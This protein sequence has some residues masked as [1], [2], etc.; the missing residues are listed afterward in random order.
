MTSN[1]VPASDRPEPSPLT[2]YLA[3]R[4]RTPN[5]AAH[6]YYRCRKVIRCGSGLIT[7]ILLHSHHTRRR[8]RSTE[9]QAAIHSILHKGHSDEPWSSRHTSR[10]RQGRRTA[11]QGPVHPD[12]DALRPESDVTLIVP[13]GD[14]FVITDTV[15]VPIPV[16]PTTSVTATNG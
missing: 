4:C 14:A 9:E 10:P 8:P 12:T 7:F 5:P 2:D 11:S 15:A 6:S 1:T 16:K 13:V 3:G